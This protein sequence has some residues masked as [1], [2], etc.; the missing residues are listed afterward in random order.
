MHGFHGNLEDGDDARETGDGP[1]PRTDPEDADPVPADVQINFDTDDG[2]LVE[3]FDPRIVPELLARDQSDVN[4]VITHE[5]LNRTV[6]S[7][8]H[9]D[10]SAHDEYHTRGL[11]KITLGELKEM[12]ELRLD[13]NALALLRNRLELK[14][15][16]PE[17]IFPANSP[18][19][20]WTP[21]GTFLDLAVVIPRNIGFRALLPRLETAYLHFELALSFTG[22]NRQLRVSKAMLGFDPTEATLW[23]GRCLGKDVW[24]GMVHRDII[25]GDA[26]PTTIGTGTGS[27]TALSK[28][29]YHVMVFFFAHAFTVAGFRDIYSDEYPDLNDWDDYRKT[30][31][32][33]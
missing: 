24:L 10:H 29:A 3:P 13:D 6:L 5:Q 4:D 18:D 19:I 8:R 15:D 2:A 31:S 9:R 23:I 20:T 32:V 33:M 28:T 30:N 21:K 27:P 16:D 1:V 7:L 22:R 12:Y 11:K 14:T 25:N 26:P 17:F